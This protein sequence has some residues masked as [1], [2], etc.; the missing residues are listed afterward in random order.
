MTT[1]DAPASASQDCCGPSQASRKQ[2]MLIIPEHQQELPAVRDRKAQLHIHC[3][4]QVEVEPATSCLKLA[5]GSRAVNGSRQ[6]SVVPSHM[7]PIPHTST[8][9]PC[10]LSN[11]CTQT[12]ARPSHKL[13]H[14]HSARNIQ[15]TRLQSGRT[16]L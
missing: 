11:L 16:H 10:G 3:P 9:G 4:K 8:Q 5:E 1:H 6:A 7:P 15:Q 2:N 13:P 14:G 12:L